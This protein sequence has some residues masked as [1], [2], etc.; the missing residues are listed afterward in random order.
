LESFF[1]VIE[2]MFDACWR[3]RSVVLRFDRRSQS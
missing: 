2:K 1:C 3:G